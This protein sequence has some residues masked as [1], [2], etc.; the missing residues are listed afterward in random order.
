MA[1]YAY[2][3]SDNVVTEVVKGPDEGNFDWEGYFGN[4]KGLLCKRTSYNTL[5]GVHKLGGTPFRKNFASVGGTYNLSKDAFIPL[6]NA[7]L[8]SWILDETTCQWKAPVD[9]PDDG[10]PYAWDEAN[11][12]WVEAAT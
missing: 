1:H 11:T 6:K 5:S 8:P 12:Q 9:K 4:K 2:I 10:K 3:N 7:D